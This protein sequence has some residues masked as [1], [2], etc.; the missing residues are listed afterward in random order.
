MKKLHRQF[1]GVLVTTIVIL[2]IVVSLTGVAVS[3]TTHQGRMSRS[4]IEHSRRMAVVDSQMERLYFDWKALMASMPLGQKP[5]DVQLAALQTTLPSS[6]AAVHPGFA[7]LNGEFLASLDGL[8]VYKIE[9]VDIY[10]GVVPSGTYSVSTGPLPGFEGFFSVNHTYRAVIGFRGNTFGGTTPTTLLE[11]TFIRSEAPVFQ[12][13]IYYEDDMELH[14]GDSMYMSGPVMSNHRIYASVLSGKTLTFGSSVMAN[15][16][17]NDPVPGITYNNRNPSDAGYVEGLPPGSIYSSSYYESPTYLVG[18]A[19]QLS[20]KDRLEPAGRELRDEFDSADANPNNDGFRELIEKPD[21]AA[22]DPT[23]IA[24]ARL[25]SQATLRLSVTMSGGSPV[26]NA[27]GYNGATL[28]ASVVTK[29]R[30]AVG[31]RTTV[32]DKREGATVSVTPLN[33][34]KLIEAEQLMR[35]LT[36]SST[37]LTSVLYL[38][39]DSAATGDKWAFRLENASKLPSYQE[40]ANAPSS[41]RGFT[42]ATAGGIY[43]KGDYNTDTSSEMVPASVMADAVMFLS[44]NWDDAR[45]AN[46]INGVDDGAGGIVADSARVATETTYRAA[47]MAGTIPSGYDPTPG[48]PSSGDEYGPGGGAHNFPRM[49][50]K[51]T[52]VNMNFKGSMVQLFNS[53]MFTGQWQTGDV[54]HPPVRNWSANENFVKR[55]SPGLFAFSMYSRGP[56]KRL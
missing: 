32:Y 6:A 30:E 10:G 34:G 56:W 46:P 17:P 48:A 24:N 14:P 16:A 42:V 44:N 40:A 50:E 43:L 4:S 53:K 7:S 12:A 51:W 28:P 13:G 20:L 33:V 39:D 21:G 54:Y 52:G 41:Q 22:Y 23:P 19:R 26:V 1:G 55:P 37:S 3:I 49:L 25:Y 18:K 29:I 27:T 2:V 31:A 36:G 38:S 15:K 5:T 35:S 47:I 8:D 9:E 11:R 45:A